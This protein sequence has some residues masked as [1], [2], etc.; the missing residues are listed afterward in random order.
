MKRLDLTLPTPA[1][2]LALDEALVET[3]DVAQTHDELLRL[4]EPRETFVV[5]GR[6]SPLEKEVNVPWCESQEIKMFRR[7]SGGASIVTGPGC[8]MY[9]V[10]LDLKKRPHLRMLDQA[11]TTVMKTMASALAT[12][13]IE[14]AI[15]GTCDLTIDRR[16]VSGNSLRVKRNFLIYHGTMI[17]DF[18]TAT[19]SKCLGTPVRQPDYRSN[20]SHEDFLTSIPATTEQ[21]RLAISEAWQATEAVTDWPA[22]LTQQLAEQKYRNEQWLRR[23]A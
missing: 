20:R 9:A 1:E 4:W 16:K 13:G 23:V 5:V 10:L 15:E 2:N 6:S 11:H 19:I 12:L 8:L 17:C 22:E 21:L 3:A 7:T 18:D 14:T